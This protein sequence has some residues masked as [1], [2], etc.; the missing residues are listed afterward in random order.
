MKKASF[1]DVMYIT[2]GEAGM[3]VDT[4][5]ALWAGSIVSL[6]TNANSMNRDRRITIGVHP[7]PVRRYV[8]N[9]NWVISSV[10]VNR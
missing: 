4:L 7:A 3:Y 9:P 6:H 10:V 5:R 1:Y 2:Q 8:Y